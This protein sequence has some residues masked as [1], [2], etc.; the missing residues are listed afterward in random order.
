MTAYYECTIYEFYLTDIA[1]TK[2]FCLFQTTLLL[3]IDRLKRIILINSK[4]LSKQ[5]VITNFGNFFT[6][7]IFSRLMQN[8]NRIHDIRYSDPKILTENDSVFITMILLKE[9]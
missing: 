3:I 1:F 2:L 6:R 5:R 7:E 4:L 8:N 9:L